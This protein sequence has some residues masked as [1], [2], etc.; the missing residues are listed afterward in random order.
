MAGDVGPAAVI[1][2]R[3]ADEPADGSGDIAEADVVSD[4]PAA[5]DD[6][7]DGPVTQRG[8][9]WR[10]VGG[11]PIRL[12]LATGLVAVVAISVL[13]GWLGQRAYQERQREQ[14]E[15]AF[16]Q[17]ARQGALDLTSVDYTR[18]EADVHRVL[19][20]STGTF[21]NDFEMRSPPFIQEVL[22]TKTKSVGS[23]AGAGLESADKGG[24]KVLVAV[25]VKTTR[26]GVAEPRVKGW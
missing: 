17:A 11:S 14:D 21:H 19:A 2:D 10:K 15:T 22:R 4:E 3:D 7:V 25:Q 8:S 12:A 20:S 13:A 23:I 18:V 1:A 16:V 6:I 26:E 9:L 24:A 5:D